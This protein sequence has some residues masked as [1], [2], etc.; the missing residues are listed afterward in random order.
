MAVCAYTDLSRD[1]GTW[2]KKKK[3][4]ET[5]FLS[6]AKAR[7]DACVCT[8]PPLELFAQG[9]CATKGQDGIN[10]FNDEADSMYASPLISVFPYLIIS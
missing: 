1:L 5:K 9:F 4:A 2:E 7:L 10:K 8:L 3:D 6:Y